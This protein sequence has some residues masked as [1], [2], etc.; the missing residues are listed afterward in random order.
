MSRQNE[1]SMNELDKEYSCKD[2]QLIQDIFAKQL[3][4][5]S[6]GITYYPDAVKKMDECAQ[7]FMGYESLVSLV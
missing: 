1:Y 4:D 7:P 5:K 2:M 6:H 3:T